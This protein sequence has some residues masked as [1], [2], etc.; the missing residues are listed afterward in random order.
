MDC[1]DEIQS[2]VLGAG[3][4]SCSAEVTPIMM[5]ELIISGRENPSQSDGIGVRKVSYIIV[6]I[7]ISNGLSR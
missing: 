7:E 2:E 1:M 3:V 6:R 4:S 5:F